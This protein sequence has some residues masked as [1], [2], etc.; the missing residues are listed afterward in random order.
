M[1][2][3]RQKPMILAT[4]PVEFVISGPRLGRDRI[5]LQ[6]R[7]VG[8]DVIAVAADPHLHRRTADI[9]AL[10]FGNY[11]QLNV[12]QSKPLEDFE[13]HSDHRLSSVRFAWR[14]YASRLGVDAVHDALMRSMPD[15][16]AA[17]RSRR[18]SDVEWAL[19]PVI[20]ACTQAEERRRRSRRLFL[21]A[22]AAYA[23]IGVFFFIY[24]LTKGL[25]WQMM[26]RG[27]QQR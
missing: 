12:V 18:R 19:A 25:V 3:D 23:F 2:E 16:Q 17:L 9:L 22:V 15:L 8:L 21:A 27:N 6:S 7:D 1:I 26:P 11:R 10:L 4:S 5:L 20:Y 13:S 24:V 14:G